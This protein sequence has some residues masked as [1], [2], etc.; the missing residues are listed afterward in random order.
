MTTEA[1]EFKKK[2]KLNYPSMSNL[3][4]Q[5]LPS[6]S[7]IYNFA[8]NFF[9][10]K[11]ICIKNDDSSVVKFFWKGSHD[12]ASLDLWGKISNDEGIYIDVGSHTGLYTI[13]SLLSNEKNFVVSIEPSLVNMGRM[14]SNLRLNDLAKNSSRFLG[15][16]SKE[17]KI[18]F[19]KSNTDFSHMSKGG[20]ISNEG[21]QI[22]IIRLDDIKFADR[23]N[24]KGIKIDTEGEDYNVLLGA[25]AIIKLFLPKIII[26]VRENNKNKIKLFLDQFGY[27][28]YQVNDIKNNVD[29]SKVSIEDVINI[30]ASIN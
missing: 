22:S 4:L 18:G 30:Y 5:N 1:E 2:N 16:A 27:K 9:K 19:F 14:I 21:D 3:E 6:L 7:G 29:L 28:F 15:A 23:R 24:I 8:T 13:V 20:M 17:S 26:E 10:F 11:L 12:T 25:K